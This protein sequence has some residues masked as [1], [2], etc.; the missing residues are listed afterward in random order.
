MTNEM[1]AG[2][3]LYFFKKLDPLVN[4]GL[5]VTLSLLFAETVKRQ[6]CNAL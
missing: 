4:N 2:V 3:R 1:Q 6:G 5:T